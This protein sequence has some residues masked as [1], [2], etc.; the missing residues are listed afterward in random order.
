MIN[1]RPHGR[2]KRSREDRHHRLGRRF[3]QGCIWQ[4]AHQNFFSEQGPAERANFAF[5]EQSC[6]LLNARIKS[7]EHAELCY[8]NVSMMA[9]LAEISKCCI[10]TVCHARQNFSELSMQTYLCLYERACQRVLCP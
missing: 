3:A 2:L 5:A 4:C 8:G 9:T 7:I 6:S 1:H 10:S